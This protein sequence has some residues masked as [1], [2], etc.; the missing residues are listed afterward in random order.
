MVKPP[1]KVGTT[2]RPTIR[3]TTNDDACT[4]HTHTTTTT[5]TVTPRRSSTTTIQYIY[6]PRTVTHNATYALSPPRICHR[7]TLARITLHNSATGAM[8]DVHRASRY[9]H[10]AHNDTHTH[11]HVLRTCTCVYVHTITH[12]LYLHTRQGQPFT[13]LYTHHTYTTAHTHVTHTCCPSSTLTHCSPYTPL[14]KT[15]PR[16]R[17]A[18]K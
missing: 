16:S 7:M 18:Q 5:T 8:G 2:D 1:I 13:W 15:K 12:T 3:H 17:T 14:M 6:V 10:R 11:M 9:S 4:T